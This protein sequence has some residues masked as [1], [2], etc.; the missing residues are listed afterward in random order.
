MRR[1]DFEE[2]SAE[3]GSG[4]PAPKVDDL[5]HMLEEMKQDHA[6]RPERVREKCRTNKSYAIVHGLNKR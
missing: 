2:G 4:T 6:G 1:A 3:P 5:E